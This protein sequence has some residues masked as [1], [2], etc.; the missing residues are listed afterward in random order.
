MLPRGQALAPG[1]EGIDGE[2]VGVAAVLEGIEDEPDR[3]LARL[4]DVVAVVGHG[5]GRDV[6]RL[7]VAAEDADVE[8]GPVVDDAQLGPLGRIAAGA[9]DGHPEAGENGGFQPDLIIEA[10]V[11]LGAFFDA[12]RPDRNGKV[13]RGAAPPGS[14]AEADTG[15]RS[16]AS[17]VSAA[18]IFIGRFFLYGAALYQNDRGGEDPA[19]SQRALS[20]RRRRRMRKTKATASRATAVRAT[21]VKPRR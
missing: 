4:L 8:D 1:A 19:P 17:A 14:W 16:A 7:A 6:S 10:A 20:V 18:M 3:V 11:E 13:P 15:S 5:V 2:E 21:A 12:E 9:R